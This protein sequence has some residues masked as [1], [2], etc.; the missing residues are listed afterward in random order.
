MYFLMDSEILESAAMRRSALRI[1]FNAVFHN[2]KKNKEDSLK[3]NK[4]YFTDEIYFK[5]FNVTKMHFK[6]IIKP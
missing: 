2:S 3:N 4:I 1:N 6:I 5:T